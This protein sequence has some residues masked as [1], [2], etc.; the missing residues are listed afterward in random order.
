MVIVS[1]KSRTR[2]RSSSLAETCGALAALTK[3][4]IA[5]ASVLTTVAAYAA[6]PGGSFAAT[7]VLGAA[8]LAA[9]AGSLA[10]NQWWERDSDARMTRT[11]GRPLPMARL[12]P[13]VALGWSLYLSVLGCTWLAAWF[14]AAAAAFAAATIV[15]YGL[16]YTPMKR[17]TPWATWVGSVSG[18]LPPLIG[19][20]AA[21]DPLSAPAWLLAGVLFFWQMPHFYAIG[22]LYRE[23]YRAAGLPL[24]PVLDA[25]GGRRTARSSIAHAAALLAFVA[26][27]PAAGFAGPIFAV[28]ATLSALLLL[29]CAWRFL[30]AE[31]DR[32][33]AARTLFRATLATLPVIMVATVVDALQRA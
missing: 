8:T 12:R 33:A 19:A 29:A 18:A 20:T 32:D 9:A 2:P 21:G 14:G 1:N 5:F 27:A 23:Q 25:S 26:L 10:L 16:L 24:L 17:R 28:A 15:I 7:L 4:R 11:A 22:W 3:P 31:D 30:R 13:A 6:V